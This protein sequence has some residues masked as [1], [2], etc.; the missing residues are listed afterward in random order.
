MP[1]LIFQKSSH[2][3]GIAHL[4]FGRTGSWVGRERQGCQHS[5]QHLAGCR[6]GEGGALPRGSHPHLSVLPSWEVPGGEGRGG[7][8]GAVQ[9]SEPGPTSI[10]PHALCLP[11][12]V[13]KD[14]GECPPALPG[15]QRGHRALHGTGSGAQ[16]RL[17][18]SMDRLVAARHHGR[19]HATGFVRC[20]NGSLP[21]T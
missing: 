20:N 9:W 7:G 1:R 14:P 5:Q 17:W 21:V 19:A 12:R 8:D 13:G 15:A 18:N 16:R 11:S 2:Q 6:G 10:R 4:H 3:T